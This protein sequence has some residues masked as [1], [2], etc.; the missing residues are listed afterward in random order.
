MNILYLCDEY[1]PGKHG[2]IGSVVQTL[3]REMVKQ[4]HN[5]VVAGIYYWGYGGEDHFEDNGV[6]VYR[7]RYTLS[8]KW[9]HNHN[10]L[11]V[12][13]SYK[14]LHRLGLLQWDIKRSLDKY[15]KFLEQL[16]VKYGIDI[17]EM[18]DYCDYMRFCKEPVHFPKLSVP[19][20]VKLHGNMTYF[21]REAGM[22]EPLQVHVMEQEIFT[23]AS[24]ITSVSKYTADKTKAY[25]KIHK[26]I[27]VVYNGID[28]PVKIPEVNKI[29]GRVM[30][31]GTLV[32]KKGICQLMKAWNIVSKKIDAHL[33]VYG[34]G[35]IEKIKK[36]L[37]PHAINSVTFMGH[38][39][40][41]KLFHDISKSNVCVFPSYAEAF[42]LAPL[43]AMAYGVSVIYTKRTSGP[44]LIT[45][46]KNGLL[47]EPDSV[48]EIAEKICYM[49]L[50]DN[51]RLQL[52][53]QGQITVREKFDIRIIAKQ[54]ISF[55]QAVINQQNA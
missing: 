23:E 41:Y 35:N 7:F 42:S 5:V 54:N 33:Y 9:F 6:E 2:G 39:D 49:L 10:S 22:K 25:F 32:E 48:E 50:N 36:L 13:G 44:E 31:S 38:A 30:F 18:P 34:K 11:R 14:V 55:Y 1:P 45:D 40:R 37:T 16:I 46:G 43:E 51:V 4:G 28:T 21:A 27:K 53:A 29:P 47:I 17:V 12:R 15:R 3:G 19:V 8:S 52:A 24:G 20:V 26:E